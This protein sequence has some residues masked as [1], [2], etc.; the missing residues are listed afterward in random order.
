MKKNIT[1]V[2]PTYG[3]LHSIRNGE[4]MKIAGTNYRGRPALY[5]FHF[6]RRVKVQKGVPYV[7]MD[8]IVTSQLV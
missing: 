8:K 4:D 5:E 2:N 6:G 3:M 1:R 7:N